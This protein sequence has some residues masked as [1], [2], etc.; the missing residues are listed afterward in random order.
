MKVILKISF[1]AAR[2]SSSRA[3]KK[4]R[5]RVF[6]GCRRRIQPIHNSI[7]YNAYSMY[8]DEGFKKGLGNMQ[9]DHCSREVEHLWEP[10]LPRRLIYPLH[11]GIV[12]EGS[13]CHQQPILVCES[14]CKVGLLT[15]TGRQGVCV[16]GRRQNTYAV[17]VLVR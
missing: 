8:I 2:Q 14:Q 17:T 4:C 10:L 9:T 11:I 13:L 15:A 7:L 1:M 12:I 3:A 5:N 16:G 6:R